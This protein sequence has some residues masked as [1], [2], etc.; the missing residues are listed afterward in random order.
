MGFEENIFE[1]DDGENILFENT[2]E[3]NNE[4]KWG[5]QGQPQDGRYATDAISMN[6]SRDRSNSLPAIKIN[7]SEL[8]DADEFSGKGYDDTWES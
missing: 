4:E 5:Q 8:S 2:S 1:I 3:L 7:T 6:K